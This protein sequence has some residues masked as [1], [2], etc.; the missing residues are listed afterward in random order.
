MVRKPVCSPADHHRKMLGKM[1]GVWIAWKSRRDLVQVTVNSVMRSKEGN[2]P[3]ESWQSRYNIKNSMVLNFA[4]KAGSVDPDWPSIDWAERRVSR[5]SPVL[6]R[7][8]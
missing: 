6:T 3:C 7:Y 5:S 8:S 1:L 4:L 2:R